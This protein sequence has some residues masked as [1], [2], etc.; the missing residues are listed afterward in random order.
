MYFAL[1]AGIRQIAIRP[2]IQYI[3]A[4]HARHGLPPAIVAAPT[5]K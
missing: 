5:D 1:P 4:A 3:G 2:Y